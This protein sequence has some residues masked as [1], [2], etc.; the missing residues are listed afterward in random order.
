MPFRKEENGIIVY[1]T[2]HK[3]M[4]GWG[5]T[6]K[7]MRHDVRNPKKENEHFAIEQ[8]DTEAD[9]RAK[10]LIYLLEHKLITL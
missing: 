6:V 2:S 4:D 3:N 7:A 5:W 8:A 1:V 9:A 10:M